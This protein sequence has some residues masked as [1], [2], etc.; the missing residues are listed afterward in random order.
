MKIKI[1][2]IGASDTVNKIKAA[3]EEFE[4]KADIFIFPYSHKEEIVKI[5]EECQDNVDIILFSGQVPYN[6]ARKMNLLT[7]PYYFIPFTGAILYKAF[8]AMKENGIDYKRISFDTI[9]EKDVTEI[10]EELD[11]NIEKFYVNA[12]SEDID[13][14]KVADFHYQLWQKGAVNV[15]CTCLNSTYMKLK[16]LGMPVIR[17]YPTVSLIKEYLNRIIYDSNIEKA[18]SAQ[19]AVQ[20]IKINHDY[21]NISSEY[22]FLELKNTIEKHIIN[23][24]KKVIGSMFLFGRNEYLIF[25]T[26]GAINDEAHET[27][28]K[29]LMQECKK[30]KIDFDSGIG[31]GN[32]IYE[33]ETN[34]RIGMTYSEK[35]QNNCLYMVGENGIIK[36]PLYS[37]VDEYESYQLN[38]FDE[39]IKEVA[40]N[41]NLSS[42]YIS[43][44]KAIISSKNRNT[45][46]AE[47]LS[48]YLSVSVR[49]SRR[50]L[51]QLINGG[52]AK[53]IGDGKKNS[54]GRP[55]NIYEIDLR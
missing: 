10:A 11:L 47:E 7:K 53:V 23:Y 40:A 9:G 22:S 21:A 46:T 16:D 13:Y 5:L 31:F 55:Y 33:A 20:I 4:G 18:K 12:F 48:N 19:I 44:L 28:M 29:E 35:N 14:D 36:G 50:I 45:F 51:S 15:A 8:W 41:T 26:R 49:S 2:I 32:T 37:D 30:N 38:T 3:S 34:A 43:K 27:Y 24:T 1:S 39:Y 42:A 52:Y 6:L 25:T 54:T 17:L